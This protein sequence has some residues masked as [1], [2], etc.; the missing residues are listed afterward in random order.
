MAIIYNPLTQQFLSEVIKCR[1]TDMEEA[2]N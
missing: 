1:V 2:L